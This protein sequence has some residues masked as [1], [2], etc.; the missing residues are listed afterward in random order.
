MTQKPMAE[1]FY[2]KRIRTQMIVITVILATLIPIAIIDGKKY[3]V[4]AFV[5]FLVA[6]FVFVI[7]QDSNNKVTVYATGIVQEK[8]A[9]PFRKVLE[10]KWNHIVFLKDETG[11]FTFGRSFYIQDDQERPYRIH[12]N[13]TLNHYQDLLQYIVKL[14]PN[15][16]VDKRAMQMVSKLGLEAKIKK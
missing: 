13:S 3:G 8:G 12:F 11:L 10:M 1:F 16:E 6:Y 2:L 5:A 7:W 14:S 15:I 9:G 4:A